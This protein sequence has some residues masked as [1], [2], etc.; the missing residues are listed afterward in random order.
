MAGFSFRVLQAGFLVH[1]GEL[2]RLFANASHQQMP[3]CHQPD[4]IIHC[5][6]EQPA[7][8]SECFASFGVGFASAPM[9]RLAALNQPFSHLLVD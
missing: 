6:C 4:V 3:T 2:E 9:C 1:R 7:P 5:I 8:P